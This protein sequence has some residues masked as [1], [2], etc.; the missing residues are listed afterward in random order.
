M[1]FFRS[2]VLVV[3][4]VSASCR[5]D[6]Q[7]GGSTIQQTG[8]ASR[9]SEIWLYPVKM[10]VSPT[11]EQLNS[12]I[13]KTAHVNTEQHGGPLYTST[14]LNVTTDIANFIDIVKWY[15][16]KLKD[17]DVLGSLKSFSEEEDKNKKASDGTSR[18]FVANRPALTRFRFTPDQKQV[19]MIL[20]DDNGDAVT[21]L[22]VGNTR[23]TRIE[24]MRHH[25]K[26]GRG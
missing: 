19:T 13:K 9:F 17:T 20:T 16:E 3:A 5:L 26:N 15:S 23:E 12:L 11:S 10:P 21:I 1:N 2:L 22:L 25:G 14:S 6:A 4:A 8:E 24:V 7:E 18:T